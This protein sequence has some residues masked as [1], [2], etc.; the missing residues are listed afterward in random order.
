[1]D[2]DQI[3]QILIEAGAHA[4][5]LDIYGDRPEIVNLLL[6]QPEAITGQTI[7]EMIA[8][9]WPGRNYME[10][11]ARLSRE[12]WRSM[13]ED[14]RDWLLAEGWYWRDT[15][16]GRRWFPPEFDSSGWA[17]VQQST[18]GAAASP[19]SVCE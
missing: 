8:P 12:P 6:A 11:A 3:H 7:P 5:P 16:D 9:A 2:I 1:M 14:I 4:I 18:G 17:E 10:V 13:A 19:F 15:R